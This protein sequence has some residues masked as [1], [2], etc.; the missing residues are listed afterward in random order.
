GV[1]FTIGASASVCGLIGALLYYGKSRGGEFGALVVS[2]V[3]GW[4]IGLVLIGFFL[5]SI[6]NWGHGGGLLGGLVLAALLGYQERRLAGRL[7][8]QLAL[9]VVLITLAILGWA[10]LQSFFYF[11]R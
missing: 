3:R 8:R 11:F 7:I 6:N 4:I 5:P 2:Q 10:V 1:M 9:L